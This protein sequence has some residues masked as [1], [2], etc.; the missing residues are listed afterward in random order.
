LI[1]ASLKRHRKVAALALAL[2][3]V[4]TAGVAIWVYKIVASDPTGTTANIEVTP[5][6]RTGTVG[7]AAI[8]P[9]GKHIVYS[10][11]EAGRESLWLRQVAASSAQQIVP[12]AEVSYQGLT[13]SLD[14][15]HINFARSELNGSVR[16]LYR[17]PALGGVPTK[18]LD[19]ID[20]VVTFSPDGSRMAF[21]RYSGDESAVMIAD[22]DGANQRKL[23]TRPMTDYFKVPSWS[24]DGKLIAC[25]TGSGEPYDVH[26]TITAVRVEDGTE[27]PVTPKKWAWTRWVE[28]LSDG[29]GLLITA[30]ERHEAP[31]Q[32]WRISYPQGSVRKLTS[33]SKMYLS[34]S[35]TEDSRTM[36]AVQTELLSDIWVATDRKTDEIKKITFG[37]GSYESSCYA[38]DGRI[39]YSSAPS[40]HWDIW[41]MNGDGSNPKQLTADAGVNLHQAVSPDGRY[42]VFASN[43]AGVF[44]IWRMNADGSNPVQLTHGSGEKFPDC[45]PDSKWIIYNSVATNQDHNAVWKVSIEGGEPVRLTGSYAY[46][47]AI[48]PDG[49]HIAYFYR[50]ESTNDQ[51]RIVIIPFAGGQPEKSIDI[52][53]GLDPLPYVRWSPDGL[54]LTYPA[55]RNGV[56]NVWMQPLGGGDVKQV[57]DF[58]AEGKLQFDW[59]RDGK[60]LVLLRRLWTADLALVKNFAPDKP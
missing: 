32:I 45:S 38:P 4:G 54:S 10:V 53:Q 1:I 58:K 15:N 23:A 12:P 30:R 22:A 50:D 21:V 5:L 41:I 56:Y 60:Q 6:T 44:N 55:A 59:S 48:S 46:S 24:P 13:F 42:I 29:S 19:G 27:I 28:W 26:N 20:S 35:L 31:D 25:S 8:S 3:I 18:L 11:R 37:T 33:D 51:Y 16:A 7:G 43:R 36:L 2:L 9:D 57:T 39:V 17:M 49:K 34:I 52:A 14:G 47:P 40:G